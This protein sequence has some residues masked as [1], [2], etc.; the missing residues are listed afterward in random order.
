MI[1]FIFLG[2]SYIGTVGESELLNSATAIELSFR[3]SR[4]VRMLEDL[5]EV[6]RFMFWMMKHSLTEVQFNGRA[7]F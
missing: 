4:L 2:Q 1:I 3:E 7:S 6:A 5:H